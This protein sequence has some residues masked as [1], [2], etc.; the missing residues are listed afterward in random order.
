[1]WY[2]AAEASRS[3]NHR[4]F[5]GNKRHEEEADRILVALRE[6]WRL[7]AR[8]LS[9]SDKRSFYNQ[10][11]VQAMLSPQSSD[12]SMLRRFFDQLLNES[13]TGALKWHRLWSMETAFLQLAPEPALRERIAQLRA[14]YERLST[15]EGFADF[16][17]SSPNLAQ[18]VDPELRS[19]ASRLVQ[20]VQRLRIGRNSVIG[21]RLWHTLFVLV[22]AALILGLI[23]RVQQMKLP[24]NSALRSI[25][26]LIAGTFAAAAG[27]CLS[28]LSRLYSIPLKGDLIEPTWNAWLRVRWMLSPAVSIAQGMLAGIIVFFLL[29]SQMMQKLVTAAILPQY[30]SLPSNVEAVPHDGQLD[31]SWFLESIPESS[32]DVGIL[33]VWCVLAGFAERLV[34]DLLS[35]LAAQAAAKQNK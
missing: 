8:A 17:K 2:L 35:Q 16:M 34:P 14:E 5:V 9:G 30:R 4:E 13:A 11:R 1:M 20:D 7:L 33:L 22:V 6:A 24:D 10:L 15:A 31:S 21:I 25:D 29:Q 28:M 27:A 23:F 18:S 3:S 19:Y 32:K 26:I 12:P